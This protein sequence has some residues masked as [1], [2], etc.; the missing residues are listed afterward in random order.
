MLTMSTDL[1]DLLDKISDYPG[2]Y[3]GGAT[4][5]TRRKCK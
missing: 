5:G 3:G 4:T 1:C 2:G